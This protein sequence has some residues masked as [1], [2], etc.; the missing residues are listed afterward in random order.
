MN[1]PEQGTGRFIII[2]VGSDE[3]KNPGTED[4]LLHRL[5]LSGLLYL[6]IRGK[7]HSSL[8]PEKT[9]VKRPVRFRWVLAPSGISVSIVNIKNAVL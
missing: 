1:K 5:P 4:H 3:R 2:P 9:C 8:L 6:E 7:Y